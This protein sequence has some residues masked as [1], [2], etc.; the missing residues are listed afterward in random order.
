MVSKRL[1][2]DEL[3]PESERPVTRSYPDHWRPPRHIAG[4]HIASYLPEIPIYFIPAVIIAF[5]VILI[6]FIILD[7]YAGVSVHPLGIALLLIGAFWGL[8]YYTAR[9]TR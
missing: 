8:F 4:R 6:T 5:E 7:K 9:S 3:I 1:K 2:R